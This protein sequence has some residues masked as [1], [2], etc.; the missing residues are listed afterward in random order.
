MTKKYRLKKDTPEAYA[1]AILTE[2]SDG[3]FYL[4][5][6]ETTEWGYPLW[7]I[8]HNPMWF[9]E[10]KEPEPQEW[11]VGDV[12]EMSPDRLGVVVEINPEKQNQQ[13]LVF[14]EKQGKIKQYSKNNYIFNKNDNYISYAPAIFRGDTDRLTDFDSLFRSFAEARDY[15]AS[16]FVRWPATPTSWV[17]LPKGDSK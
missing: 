10:V 8:M 6:Q 3:H 4:P 5:N 17:I 1:G 12:V 7:F 11:K 2:A 13:V 16:R 15:Y 14:W 9:E